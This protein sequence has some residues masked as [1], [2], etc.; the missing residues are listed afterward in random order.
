MIDR[1]FGAIGHGKAPSFESRAADLAQL[2]DT[3]KT[4]VPH[5][6]EH[7]A[8]ISE[9]IALHQR[10][11]VRVCVCGLPLRPRYE[12]ASSGSLDSPLMDHLFRDCILGRE[13]GV[14]V[15]A[16]YSAGFIL[17][18]SDKMTELFNKDIINSLSYLQSYDFRCVASSRGGFQA[19][20]IHIYPKRFA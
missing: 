5:E 2:W 11:I 10:H 13:S 15:L 7:T 9:I 8:S 3:L 19:H 16:R 1:Y 17:W 6:I 4:N 14:G 18:V 12:S 20:I